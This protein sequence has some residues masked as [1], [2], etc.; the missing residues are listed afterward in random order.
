[1]ENIGSSIADSRG[2]V[3][4]VHAYI[5][6]VY[7][8]NSIVK[9]FG[10]MSKDLKVNSTINQLLKFSESELK[11]KEE[12]TDAQKIKGISLIS[13]ELSDFLI[14][15]F[16]FPYYKDETF[17]YSDRLN[18]DDG[19]FTEIFAEEG[20]IYIGDESDFKKRINKTN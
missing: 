9:Y 16:A 18:P 6:L 15:L 10:E 3:N 14:K 7:S 1:M 8:S 2:V 4:G 19:L 5:G 11:N 12:L 17:L 20:G 13:D